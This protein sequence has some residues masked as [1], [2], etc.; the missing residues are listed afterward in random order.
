[1]TSTEYSEPARALCEGKW[2]LFDSIDPINH[3]EARELCRKCPLMTEC[4]VSATR[5][6]MPTGTWAA[7]LHGGRGVRP[8]DE[9]A[10]RE[11]EQFTLEAA[12]ECYNA[13]QRGVRDPRTA[14]GKKVYAR[15]LYRARRD[16][17]RARQAA[18][19]DGHGEAGYRKGCRC[20][21][22]R[23]A[24]AESARAWRR[25]QKVAA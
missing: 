6:E 23:E 2:Q 11:D 22:C 21:W 14:M 3:A 1:M 4:A 18:L 13:W 17:D 12:R 16:E 5:V 10:E 24:H 8:S 19:D 15:H 7:R 9:Q 20:E 25:K